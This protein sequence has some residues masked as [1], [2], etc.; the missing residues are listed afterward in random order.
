MSPLHFELERLYENVKTDE[1]I[2]ESLR[3]EFRRQRLI[4]CVSCAFSSTWY[5]TYERLK[6]RVERVNQIERKF[7]YDAG[8][9]GPIRP[10]WSLEL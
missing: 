2:L 10:F 6:R 4:C 5:P 7:W 3:D 9:Y 1:Q 8:N